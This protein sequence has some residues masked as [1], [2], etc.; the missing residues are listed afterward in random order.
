MVTKSG[1]YLSTS[2]LN[3]HD[4]FYD[5][6][7][8]FQFLQREPGRIIFRFIPKE[9][10]CEETRKEMQRRLLERCL[11]DVEITMEAVEEIP[12]TKR[13]KHRLLVQELELKFDDPSLQQAL[14]V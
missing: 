14:Q 13:G 5:R 8:Q 1:R 11:N 9:N 4:N 7:K 12:L 2:M 6:I 10:F 3:M